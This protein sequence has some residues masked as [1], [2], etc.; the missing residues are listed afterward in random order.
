M[1]YAAGRAG[2]LGR[3]RESSR[4]AKVFESQYYKE[5]RGTQRDLMHESEFSRSRKAP[6]A[7]GIRPA[8]YGFYRQCWR[9]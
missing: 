1:P 3:N 9:P 2:R 5:Y 7:Y 6:A 8:A 4:N